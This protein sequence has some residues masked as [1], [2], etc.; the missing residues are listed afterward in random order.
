[1]KLEIIMDKT[2]QLEE[3]TVKVLQSFIDKEVKP[4]MRSHGVPENFVLKAVLEDTLSC[5]QL[6][7]CEDTYTVSNGEYV[8]IIVLEDKETGDKY[9]AVITEF[10]GYDIILAIV[11]LDGVEQS[12]QFIHDLEP[13]LSNIIVYKWAKELTGILLTVNTQD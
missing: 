7:S 9:V 6:G 12:K 5:I 1:M 8:K 2:K 4:T 11:D 3:S 13:A 10:F